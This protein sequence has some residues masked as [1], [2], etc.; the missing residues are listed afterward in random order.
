MPWLF[1]QEEPTTG[2]YH[3]RDLGTFGRIMDVIQRPQYTIANTLEELQN[4]ERRTLDEI[5]APLHHRRLSE[6]VKGSTRELVEDTNLPEWAKTTIG[7]AGNVLTDPSTWVG[8]G[9][10]T[11][12]GKAAIKAGEVISNLSRAQ[13][14][15]K[16]Y[17]AGVTFAGLPIVKGQKVFEAGGKVAEWLEPVAKQFRYGSKIPA[18][19]E[20]LMASVKQGR[21]VRAEGGAAARTMAE[22]I[23]GRAG[24]EA[25]ALGGKRAMREAESRIGRQVVENVEK[26]RP[27]VTEDILRGIR[28][29]IEEL[30]HQSSIMTG[31]LQDDLEYLMHTTTGRGNKVLGRALKRAHL[32]LPVSDA[33]KNLLEGYYGSTLN[34]VKNTEGRWIAKLAP[35]HTSMLS[36]RIRGM[37]IADKNAL[38]EAAGLGRIWVEDPAKIVAGRYRLAE[39]ATKNAKFLD[40]L[41]D[42]LLKDESWASKAADE[43]EAKAL[44]AQGWKTLP[45]PIMK[46]VQE[47]TPLYEK[48]NG[49]HINPAI[50]GEIER[51]FTTFVSPKAPGEFAKLYGKALSTLKWVTLMPFVPYHVRNIFANDVSMYALDHGMDFRGFAWMGSIQKEMIEGGEYASKGLAGFARAAE[52]GRW[53]GTVEKAIAGGKCPIEAKRAIAEMTEQGVM[54]SG[55]YRAEAEGA[56]KIM[57]KIGT[58][59]ATYEDLARGASYLMWRAKGAAPEQAARFVFDKFYKY[60]EDFGGPADRALGQVF[61][62]WRWMRQNMVGSARNLF[63]HYGKTTVAA[64]LIKTIEDR[65][66]KEGIQY[67][68]PWMKERAGIAVGRGKKG[69]EMFMLQS[70]LPMA[71]LGNITRPGS[72]AL[73]SLSPLLRVPL[74]LAAKR[75]FYYD[76]P[77]VEYPGEREKFA[78]ISMSPWL[79]YG[80]KQFRP[81]AEP[82]RV[83]KRI[84]GAETAGGKVG[85]GVYTGLLGARTYPMNPQ[86]EAASRFFETIADMGKAN[87]ALKR[88]ER[89]GDAKTMRHL[90]QLLEEYKRKQAQYGQAAGI[91]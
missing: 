59:A 79:A 33:E 44:N 25:G 23:R 7:F 55:M 5:L 1:E 68:P 83:A 11:K 85:R 69:L 76:R 22:A 26:G 35:A 41:G 38:S 87:A 46:W 21:N 45:A 6:E 50:Y 62:F 53:L 13:Q 77:I 17:R 78:G 71:D 86:K 58:G 82:A 29:R 64:K 61:F 27:G 65:V 19:Q 16:G 37:S 8:I 9:A 40:T 88:A 89:D 52:P 14:V 63:E 54:R 90:L 72:Y 34:A 28:T 47:G 30:E 75:E 39:R 3:Y 43:V 32:G 84:A 48:L 20:A 56:T 31:S 67:Q 12:G 73:E 80:L 70:W 57:E 36:R 10:L 66:D 60:G 24:E 2:G 18:V 74:E 91:R 81:F 15:A 4:P 51:V 49:L 42:K